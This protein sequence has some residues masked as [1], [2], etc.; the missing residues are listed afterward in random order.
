MSMLGCTDTNMGS[1]TYIPHRKDPPQTFNPVRNNKVK[2]NQ[3]KSHRFEDTFQKLLSPWVEL[4]HRQEVKSFLSHSCLLITTSQPPAVS[5]SSCAKSLHLITWH[6]LARLDSTLSVETLIGLI[7]S[8]HTKGN[9]CL[10]HSNS[11]FI[12][13]SVE[14]NIDFP[15]GTQKRPFNKGKLS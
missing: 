1:L 11:Q 9:Q 15:K 13:R 10:T 14:S 5:V 4:A 6:S 3:T 12:Q 7:F 2:S 8:L